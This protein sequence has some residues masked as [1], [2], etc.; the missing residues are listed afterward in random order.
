MSENAFLRW[1]SSKTQTSWWN[2]SGDP[3]EIN[4]ALANGSMGVTMNPLLVKRALFGRPEF[5]NPKLKGI[6]DSLKGN[7]RAEEIAR[8]ITCEIAS[9]VEPIFKKTNG[10]QGYVCAQ[11]NPAKAYDSAYMFDMAK[12]LHAWAPNIAVKLPATKAALDT[13]EECVALGMT[14][15]MTV[16]YSVAQ[17]IAIAERYEKGAARARA[18]G[19]KP[20]KCYAVVMIGR[21]DDYLR[22]AAIDNASKAVEDDIVQAGVAVTKRTY[23]IYKEKDYKPILLASGLRKGFQAPELAGGDILLS[24]SPAIQEMVQ[25]YKEPFTEKIDVPVK[26]EVL[27]RLMTLRDFV[28][29]YEPDGLSLDEFIG[30]APVQRTLG[31]FTEEGWSPLTTYKV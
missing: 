30:Y 14:M 6:P 11:V 31:Q 7:D 9:M 27:D 5:W 20:E 28:R 25:V 16:G 21:L 23:A 4:D 22:E 29:A 8:R 3:D 1:M 15:V 26:K 17:S 12:R 19:I 18:N 13:L 24:L 10:A 2:D